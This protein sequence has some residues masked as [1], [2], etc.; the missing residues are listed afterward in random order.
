MTQYSGHKGEQRFSTSFIFFSSKPKQSKEQNN[1]ITTMSLSSTK[2]P[3]AA[4]ATGQQREAWPCLIYRL[5]SHRGWEVFSPDEN[6]SGNASAGKKASASSKKSNQQ[7]QSK[8]EELTVAPRKGSIEVRK[9]RLRVKLFEQNQPRDSTTSTLRDEEQNEEH[10]NNNSD[11][12]GS[13]GWNNNALVVRRKDSLLVTTRRGMGALVFRFKSLQSCVEFCD[14]LVYLNQDYFMTSSSSKFNHNDSSFDQS[15]QLQNGMDQR[16]LYV[17]EM[18]ANKRRK[19][20]MIGDQ[21]LWKSSS[22]AATAHEEN[23]G[24]EMTRSEPFEYNDAVAKQYRRKDE[25]LS[26]IVKLAHDE[27]F[28]GFVDELERGLEAVDGTAGVY[29]SLQSSALGL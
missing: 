24:D 3:S 2:R 6:G 22:N 11:F 26:Y 28:R 4:S 9:M 7:N 13:D 1:K 29:N 21:L 25:L 23:G 8:G 15:K 16:E 27:D 20:D 10:G 12:V 14:R 17:D 18:R 5:Q 19:A